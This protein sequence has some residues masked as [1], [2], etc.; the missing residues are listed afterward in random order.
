VYSS[1]TTIDENSAPGKVAGLQRVKLAPGNWFRTDLVG[2]RKCI[3]S[4][5]CPIIPS[6]LINY[7]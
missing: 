4:E 1:R 6:V 3:L 5:T 7:R 2:E